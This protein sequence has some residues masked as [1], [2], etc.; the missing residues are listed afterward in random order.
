MQGIQPRH[1]TNEEL[2]RFAADEVALLGSMQVDMQKE[3][4]RRFTALKPK[5][6]FP[7]EDDRI[8]KDPRQQELFL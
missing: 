8:N 5:E 6:K 4:L 3:L 7:P 1:L 2:I